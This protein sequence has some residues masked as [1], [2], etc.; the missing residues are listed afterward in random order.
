M[1]I[2]KKIKYIK[3]NSLPSKIGRKPII[4]IDHDDVCNNFIE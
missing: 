1:S 3:K 4:F 2:D